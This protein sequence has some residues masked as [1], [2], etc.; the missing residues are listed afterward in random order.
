M[1][2]NAKSPETGST[3]ALESVIPAAAQPKNRIITKKFLM[4]PLPAR[5]DD[6]HCMACRLAASVRMKTTCFLDPRFPGPGTRAANLAH[7]GT[8]FRHSM[9]CRV[10]APARMK[11]E[12]PRFPDTQHPRPG[13]R[14][15]H[16]EAGTHRHLFSEQPV[17]EIHLWIAL[18]F[19]IHGEDRL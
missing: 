7:I 8:R 3:A 13:A 11:F 19:K 9:A 15:F 16:G 10:A 1:L 18:G 5:L 6:G 2:I 17:P 4:I 14:H 12:V